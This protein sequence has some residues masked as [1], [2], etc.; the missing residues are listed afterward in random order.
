MNPEKDLAGMSNKDLYHLCQEYGRG[1]KV[2]R[3][4][5]SV[6]LVEVFRRK[7]HRKYGFESIHEFAAKVGGMNRA[8]VDRIIW[9]SEVLKNKPCLWRAFRSEGWSKLRVVANLATS[10]TDAFWA[11]KACTL[12]KPA[13]EVFVKWYRETYCRPELFKVENATSL[14]DEQKFF[15]DNVP[16][17]S[18]E[19]LVL[20]LNKPETSLVQNLGDVVTDGKNIVAM[21][22][23]LVQNPEDVITGE[24]NSGATET[25]S[26]QSSEDVITDAEKAVPD[27]DIWKNK[28][29]KIRFN[30][31]VRSEIKFRLFKHRLSKKRKM[32]VTSGEAFKELL[33][34]AE[35]KEGVELR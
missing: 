16:K 19:N 15:L 27:I 17:N 26:V 8:L 18:N 33:K 23:S 3:R 34:I 5:F 14:T 28:L 7:M 11:E 29:V 25:S 9:L 12:T 20:P 6:L 21:G 2:L 4:T 24:K 30:V 32:A 31:P 22:T 35:E 10:E 13:L 1:I